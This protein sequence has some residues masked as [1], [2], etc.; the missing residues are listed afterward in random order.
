MLSRRHFMMGTTSLSAVAVMGLGAR[1]A[2]G[3]PVSVGARA[4]TAAPAAVSPV[5]GSV[6]ITHD[7]TNTVDANSFRLGN[8]PLKVDF[9]QSASMDGNLEV[10]IY[11][12]QL[13]S[14]QKGEYTLPPIVVKVGGKDYQAPPIT[15]EVDR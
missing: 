9:V 15:I 8:K 13:E 5:T 14:M 1:S 2:E 12:F 10:S 11:K 7:K 6:M 3:G 4:V